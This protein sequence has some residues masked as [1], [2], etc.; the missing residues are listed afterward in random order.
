MDPPKP[1]SLPAQWCARSASD[2]SP[3]G[4][5]SPLRTATD[6]EFS[7]GRSIGP[8]GP[9][10]ACKSAEPAAAA[11]ACS[12]SSGYC[13]RRQHL[14][15]IVSAGSETCALPRAQGH[16]THRACNF[17]SDACIALPRCRTSTS[18]GQHC[19]AIECN[20]LAPLDRLGSWAV[21]AVMVDCDARAGCGTS[22]CPYAVAGPVDLY[23]IGPN[24]HVTI[25]QQH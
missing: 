22:F 2:H 15:S 18:S 24:P 19:D 6:V 25:N 17:P 10:P 3:T 13:Q 9:K 23:D 5:R 21:V 20:A 16:R 8:F 14:V 11:T 12:S 4:C 7:C 1:T